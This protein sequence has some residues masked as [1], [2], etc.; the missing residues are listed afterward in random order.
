MLKNILLFVLLTL[1][2]FSYSQNIN[3]VLDDINEMFIKQTYQVKTKDNIS[4]ATDIYLPV[5]QDC[6]MID[7]PIG[8]NTFLIQLIPKNTQY[9]IFD[10]SSVNK[11]SFSLPIIF[12]RTPYNKNGGGNGGDLFPFLGYGYAMQD[13]R[14]RYESEGVYF[15]MFSDAWAKYIYMPF[16]PIPMDLYPTSSMSNALH[17]SD[18]SESIF[19]INDSLY[20]YFDWNHDGVVDTFKLCNGDMGMFGASALGN[21]Q[22]QAVSNIPFTVNNPVKCLMPI[23]ASNE[24]YNT[25]LFHNG[26]YRNMLASGWMRGQMYDIEDTLIPYDNSL[27]NNLHSSIDYGYS[28][29]YVLTEDLLDW[30]IVN[31]I[32]SLPSGA[33]PNSP[34]RL[35]LDASP[36]SIDN[37]GSSDVNGTV[38]RYKNLNTNTYHL[39]GWWDIFINGQIETF[40]MMRDENPN[41]KQKLVIGPWTHQTIGADSVGD[42]NYPQNVYDVLGVEDF[43]NVG[44]ISSTDTLFFNQLYQSEILNWYRSNLGGEPFFIIPESNQWQVLDTVVIR[45]PSKNYIIPYYEFI[46]F[47]GGQGGLDNI[48]IQIYDSTNYT[49][50]SYSIPQQSSGV[51]ALPAP[52]SSSEINFDN[53]QDIRVYINGPSND[54]LNTNVGNYWVGLDSL[55]FKNGIVNKQLFLHQDLSLDT[56]QP[57]INEGTLSYNNDPTDPV[58]TT[59]GNN[60]IVRTPQN[61]KH[62]QG[63]MDYSNPNYA[64]Y[65]MDRPDVLKFISQPLQD[66]MLILGFPKAEI[67]AKANSFNTNLTETDFDIFVRVLDVYPDGREMFITEGAVNARARNY[68][69][70]IYQDNENINAPYENPLNDVYY[71]LKFDML[72]IGHTFGVGH[73]V[74]VLISSSNFPKYQSNPQVPLMPNEFFRWEPGDTSGYNYQGSLLYPT[75]NTITLEFNPNSPSF[76]NFPVVSELPPQ[77]SVKEKIYLNNEFEYYPNPTN[78]ILTVKFN[79]DVKTSIYIYDLSGKLIL[80][81]YVNNQSIYSLDLTTIKNGVYILKIDE[82][83]NKNELIIKTD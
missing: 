3:G 74:K 2:Y 81:E 67:Y 59:G 82:F 77:L 78:N 83:P 55:P 43:G 35:F 56:I 29:K 80:T 44:S 65:T 45:I 40:N 37:N 46:N 72:P 66:T 62:S 38:S 31:P 5:M 14:G 57:I 79:T 47:I 21:S 30:F 23:V 58:L 52:I 15:P 50:L 4:L 33:Y 53:I 16:N 54:A 75:S 69:Q 73:Q 48:P 68:A 1:S 32:G 60:M 7:I 64:P 20:R 61:D 63:S 42:V 26:V 71:L 28:D 41:S 10:T 17:H 19:F 51:I 70:S 8:N 34:N 76:I 39:T 11:N 13:M 12:T 22:Y 9:I 24:H 49:D 27:S 18:G 25:T 36:V 6:V